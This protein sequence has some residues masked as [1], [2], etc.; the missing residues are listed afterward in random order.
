LSLLTLFCGYLIIIII[1]IIA[2]V[3]RLNLQV[4]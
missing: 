4:C 2:F 3:F 1:I